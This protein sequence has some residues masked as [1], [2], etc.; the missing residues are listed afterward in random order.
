MRTV[1]LL[2]GI[3]GSALTLEGETV[4]PPTPAELVLG[5]RRIGKLASPRAV[6]SDL[7]R[8]VA[9]FPIYQ[10]LIDQLAQWGFA[11][12]AAGGRSGRLV[13]WPYDWRVD[14]RASAAKLAQDLDQLASQGAEITLLAHSMGGLV[15]RCALELDQ[16]SG[17]GWRASVRQLVTMGTPHRGAPVALVYALGQQSTL[18][19]D[20]SD[21]RTLAANPSFPSTYQLIPPGDAFGFWSRQG[22]AVPLQPVDALAPNVFGL[23]AENVRAAQELHRALG[24]KPASCRYFSF[25]GRELETTIRGDLR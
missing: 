8:S 25:V 24:A 9:C 7:I 13:A 18:G 1:V 3:M 12:A 17:N 5:Y 22:G 20:K 21:I 4:W 10:S 19:L 15:S 2:P 11:E 6:A 23:A 16:P 14:L